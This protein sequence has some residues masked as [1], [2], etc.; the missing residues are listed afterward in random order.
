M[1]DIATI[2]WAIW[3]VR[4]KVCFEKT[5]INNPFDIIVSSCAFMQYWV[6]LYL[7]ETHKLIKDG[8]DLMLKLLLRSWGR[9]KGTRKDSC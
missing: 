7:E 8:V 3:K 1:L 4:N 6:G 5:F 2:C 9:R